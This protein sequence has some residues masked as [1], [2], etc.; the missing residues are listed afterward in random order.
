M[1]AH[2]IRGLCRAITLPSCRNYY[3]EVIFLEELFMLKAEDIQSKIGYH[4]KKIGLLYQAFT[5][6]SYAEENKQEVDNEV[7][8]FYGD[9]VLD[10][11]VM[12]K[13]SEYY[14]KVVEGD[15]FQSSFDEGQLTDIKKK[16]VCREMLSK[17]IRRME[18]QQYL[19]LGK[20]DFEQKVWEQESVQEDLFEAIIG[21]VA[22]DSNWDIDTLTEVLERMLDLDFYLQNGFVK[23]DNYVEL[24]QQWCQQKYH[25][26]P[27]YIFGKEPELSDSCSER[28]GENKYWCWLSIAP[29][30]CFKASGKTK[31]QARMAVAEKAYQHLEEHK[32]ISP[33][34]CTIGKPDL[35]KSIN[36]LQELYQKGYICEPQYVFCETYDDNG[37]PIWRCECNLPSMAISCA[38]NHPSK[39]QGKKMVAYK[40]VIFILK[41]EGYYET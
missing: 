14:G 9:K 18:L 8:E 7:L 15:I 27:E 41:A 5:R 28:A 20:G 2:G 13:M 40:L 30:D 31:S 33:L 39:K 10:F 34:V 32:L 22:I 25:R 29:F 38:V 6:K 36:Q 1:E 21:A 11:I 26:L 16:F 19:L 37:N 23:Q 24:L 3:K 17:R 12:K 4:F 35:N